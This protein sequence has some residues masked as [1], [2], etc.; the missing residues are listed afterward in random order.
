MEQANVAQTLSS[1]HTFEDYENSK[2]HIE[3]DLARR[4]I[5]KHKLPEASLI[6]FSEG[7]NIVFSYGHNKVI[8]IFPPFHQSQFESERLVLKHIRH[9]ITQGNCQRLY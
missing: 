4:I 9:I 7:T 3:Y 6:L 8:T 1:I 2:A 5:H